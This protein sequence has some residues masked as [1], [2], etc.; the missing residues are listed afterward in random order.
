[1]TPRVPLA[2][3]R[4]LIIQMIKHF[5]TTVFWRQPRCFS[6]SWTVKKKKTCFPE[7]NWDEAQTHIPLLLNATTSSTIMHQH[8]TQI[9]YILH[10]THWYVIYIL[11]TSYAPRKPYTYITHT[12]HNIHAHMH[13]YTHTPYIPYRAYMH[14]NHIPYTYYTQYIILTYHTHHIYYWG[15]KVCVRVGAPARRPERSL[16][17]AM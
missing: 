5:L 11:H 14:H 16:Y 9:I 12:I 17:E 15:H 7:D 1:M 4:N 13:M 10:M 2:A 6:G 3:L 8:I